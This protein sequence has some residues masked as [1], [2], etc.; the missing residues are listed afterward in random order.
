MYTLTCGQYVSN[1]WISLVVWEYTRSFS[2]IFYNQRVLPCTKRIKVL[3]KVFIT[4]SFFFGKVCYIFWRH[5][6]F[7]CSFRT[8]TLLVKFVWLG[9]AT[10]HEREHVLSCLLPASLIH[11][12]RSPEK[13]GWRQAHLFGWTAWGGQP[14]GLFAFFHVVFAVPHL[15]LQIC[16]CV[17]IRTV[18]AQEEARATILTTQ[19]QLTLEAV[20]RP[21]WS[22]PFCDATSPVSFPQADYYE[23]PPLHHISIGSI[24]VLL[25][26]CQGEVN[27]LFNL[28]LHLSLWAHVVSA[29]GWFSCERGTSQPTVGLQVTALPQPFIETKPNHIVLQFP[30]QT[31]LWRQWS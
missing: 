17:M 8:R 15:V 16:T 18:A 1:F 27:D 3:S 9:M 30:A 19:T 7:F 14:V 11:L 29:A 12:P 28:S 10:F 26:A 25:E 2:F 23:V 4:Y 6:S 5:V 22:S 13:D 31:T 20:P 24:R 21:W